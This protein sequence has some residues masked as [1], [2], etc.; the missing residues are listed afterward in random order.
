MGASIQCGAFAVYRVAS[1]CWLRSPWRIQGQ[2]PFA[3]FPPVPSGMANSPL[4]KPPGEGTGPT[5]HA[6]SRAIIVGRVPSRGDQDV[7]ERAVNASVC[8]PAGRP[9]DHASKIVSHTL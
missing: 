9:F 2:P 6:D 3:L 5:T 7:F 1:R 8:S 4:K